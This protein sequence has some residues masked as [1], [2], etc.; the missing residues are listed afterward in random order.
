[1]AMIYS[2]QVDNCSRRNGRE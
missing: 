2:K 1:M